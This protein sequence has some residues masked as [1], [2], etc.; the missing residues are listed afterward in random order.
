MWLSQVKYG[1]YG[2]GILLSK[3]IFKKSKFFLL[4]QSSGNGLVWRKSAFRIEI[5]E[6]F[7]LTILTLLRAHFQSLLNQNPVA[8]GCMVVG[9]VI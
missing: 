3:L 8:W 5:R 7:F 9:F 6:L 2:A 1:E 4:H